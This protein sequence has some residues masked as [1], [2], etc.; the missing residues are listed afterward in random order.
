M[1]IIF[2]NALQAS[3][4]NNYITCNVWEASIKEIRNDPW[5]SYV[6]LGSACVKM[7]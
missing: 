2:K 3:R 4:V 6:T 5:K 7:L 1:Q